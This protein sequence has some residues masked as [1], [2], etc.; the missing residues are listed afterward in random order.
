MDNQINLFRKT[1]TREELLRTSFENGLFISPDDETAGWAI[2]DTRYIESD[3]NWVYGL[4]CKVTDGSKLTTLPE[5]AN[6][7]KEAQHLK[8]YTVTKTPFFFNFKTQ[9][10]YTQSQ[11]L[12]SRSP[13][14]SSEI[15]KT[16]LIRHFNNYILDLDV[17]SIPEKET[18]SK[19]MEDFKNINRAEFDL[20]GP[21]ILN[22]ERIR[23]IIKEF[24]PTDTNGIVIVLKNYLNGLKS[25]TEEFKSLISYVLRGGGKGTF[26]GTH[27]ETNRTITVKT[28][29][30]LRTLHVSKKLDEN[31]SIEDIQ[32]VL[33]EIISLN[34]DKL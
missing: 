30:K 21:N 10:I 12:I 17:Q 18:F 25:H 28:E 20:F 7:L 14:S 22:D 26:T 3:Y 24:N 34:E 4:L 27:K 32:S 2:D 15:W 6:S 31:S 19:K 16:I 11:Y 13:K 29:S 33:R 23:D 9:H 8:G 1:I 5:G